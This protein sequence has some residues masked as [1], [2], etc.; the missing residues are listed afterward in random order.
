MVSRGE[1]A[2]QVRDVMAT[3]RRRRYL[4]S[5]ARVKKCCRK[6]VRTEQAGP[7]L[8]MRSLVI[9]IAVILISLLEGHVAKAACELGKRHELVEAPELS[10]IQGISSMTWATIRVKSKPAPGLE[11]CHIWA[12]S[13][14]TG[15]T[16]GGG[17]LASEA[18]AI[19]SVVL[20]GVEK[21]IKF[22]VNA[23]ATAPTGDGVIEILEKTNDFQA[24]KDMLVF[25]NIK[26]HIKPLAPPDLCPFSAQVFAWNFG[27][28]PSGLL[29][30]MRDL[31]PEIA[32]GLQQLEVSTDSLLRGNLPPTLLFTLDLSNRRNMLIGSAPEV[33][34]DYAVLFTLLDGRGCR[35]GELYVAIMV[36]PQ[37]DEPLS[38]ITEATAKQVCGAQF[39]HE[40]T[41]SWKVSGVQLATDVKIEVIGPDGKVETLGTETLEGSR[42]FSPAYPGGG[43]MK[44]KVTAKD[45]S[46]SSSSAQS[47]VQ[48]GACQ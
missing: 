39:S 48:L 18:I 22:V 7:A 43:P 13:K 17:V 14:M 11:S 26:V 38:V 36:R 34:A 44:I 23:S 12:R 15:V 20:F 45:A 4:N 2:I 31:P 3:M 47:S 27:E 37:P 5:K 19:S 32:Q 46:N 24:P 30:H 6:M 21:E 28:V 29:N 33:Q 41:V 16:D 10:F 1:R 9:L 42:R 8:K 40:L 35:R 25:G